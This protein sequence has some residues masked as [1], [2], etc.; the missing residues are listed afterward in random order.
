MA[1][2]GHHARLGTRLRAKLCRGHYFKRLNSISFQGT[3]PT[4]PPLQIFRS[5]FLRRYSPR[6]PR[7]AWSEVAA[8]DTGAGLPQ[9]VPMSAFVPVCGDSTISARYA[10]PSGRTA[11]YR[12]SSSDGRSTGSGRGALH[13]G[14]AAACSQD[15]AGV[16][17]TSLRSPSRLYGAAWRS[18]S[19][20]L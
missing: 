10:V 4:D 8:T 9:I 7:R 2:T 6:P 18:F 5:G 13:S 14:F 12:G 1:V 16:L 11:R 20:V 17:D 19:R 15:R 3:T